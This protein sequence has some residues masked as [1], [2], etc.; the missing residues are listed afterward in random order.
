[1]ADPQ[2]DDYF[3]RHLVIEQLSDL[4]AKLA[5][6]MR[7]RCL[8]FNCNSEN[9]ASHRAIVSAL[10][11]EFEVGIYS[12]NYDDVALRAWPEAFTGFTGEMFDA[13]EIAQRNEWGFIYHR[14]CALFSDRSANV[15][16]SKMEKRPVRRI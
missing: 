9:F 8:G 3:Y 16:R 14:Q 10:R 4:L 13:R 5:A 7:Q 11:D 1:M 2:K 12:L 15:E 6:Y